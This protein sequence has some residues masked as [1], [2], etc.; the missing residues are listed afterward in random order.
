MLKIVRDARPHIHGQ[1]QSVHLARLTRDGEGA[2]APV[3][4]VQGEAAD[5]ADAQPQTREQ[6]QNRVV[7][8]PWRRDV[9]APLHE[10]VDG[11]SEPLPRSGGPFSPTKG[12]G[13]TRGQRV[14]GERAPLVGG[15]ACQKPLSRGDVT[16]GGPRRELAAMEPKLAI[17]L[18]KRHQRGGRGHLGA[19][20]G[21]LVTQVAQQRRQAAPTNGWP[22]TDG[23]M[24][25]AMCA[26]LREASATSADAIH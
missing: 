11:R 3:E 5:L 12:G 9:A 7:P 14:Q 2:N 21:P 26:S 22:I 17:F 23:P 4:V 13:I 16:L 6:K 10:A 19:R 15:P 8:V 18:E 24:K 25:A 1:G 20:D